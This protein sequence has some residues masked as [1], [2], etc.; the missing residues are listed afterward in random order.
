VI[1][2]ES[3][4]QTAITKSIVVPYLASLTNDDERAE[5][6]ARLKKTLNDKLG[7]WVSLARRSIA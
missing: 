5:E 7:E 6:I 3:A 4:Q 1:S 2:D